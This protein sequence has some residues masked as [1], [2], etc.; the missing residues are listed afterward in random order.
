MRSRLLSGKFLSQ[1]GHFGFELLQLGCLL[2]VG[3]CVLLFESV[4]HFEVG[5]LLFE[6]ERL[7]L[8]G[9]T[10]L[11]TRH[12]L[13]ITALKVFTLHQNFLNFLTQPFSFA[14]YFLELLKS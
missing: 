1:L 9:L 5:H 12:L 4:G 6:E 2:V 10:L 3:S 11:L 14:F 8:D 7:G 13:L